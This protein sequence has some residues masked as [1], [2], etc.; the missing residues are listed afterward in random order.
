MSK[1][2][3][4]ESAITIT[5]ATWTDSV[6]PESADNGDYE[7]TGDN[8]RDYQFNNL[9]DAADVMVSSLKEL[10]YH[11]SVSSY[12]NEVI[13]AIDGEQDYETGAIYYDRCVLSVISNSAI[14]TDREK[15]IIRALDYL[16]NK[17][18][19]A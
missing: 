19:S 12:V 15:R 17:K 2:Q 11:D 4:N 9:I 14:R 8:W 1:N 5:V 3:K 16:I 10:G 7:S 13:Y 18:L 6:S